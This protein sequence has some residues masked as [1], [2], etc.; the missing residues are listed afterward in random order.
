MRIP[1]AIAH[2]N[3]FAL[4]GYLKN[5]WVDYIVCVIYMLTIIII[6]IIINEVLTKVKLSLKAPPEKLQTLRVDYLN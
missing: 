2:S 4:H 3:N 1:N 6:I 5:K